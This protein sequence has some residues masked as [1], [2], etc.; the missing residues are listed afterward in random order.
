MNMKLETLKIIFFWSQTQANT[1]D[2][3]RSNSQI[4]K[5]S[6]STIYYSTPR[7]IIR[8]ELKESDILKNRA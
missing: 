2:V 1:K 3:V 4:K 8:K 7:K 6:H 5:S